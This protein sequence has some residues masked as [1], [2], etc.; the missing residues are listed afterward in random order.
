MG[1][2]A[3]KGTTVDGVLLYG[4]TA[5]FS[6]FGAKT[7]T[8]ER[9]PVVRRSDLGKDEAERLVRNGGGGVVAWQ[10]AAP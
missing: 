3:Q 2:N 8:R 5:E 9:A 1:V 6:T 10:T 4:P 7:T